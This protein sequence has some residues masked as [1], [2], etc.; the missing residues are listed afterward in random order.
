MKNMLIAS[1]LVMVFALSTV[2]QESE[3]RFA[4][5]PNEITRL[6]RIA[7]G[8]CADEEKAQPIWKTIASDNPELFLF[9]GDNVYADINRDQWVNEPDV[10]ALEFSYGKLEEH[11]EFGAFRKTVPILAGWDDHDYG[12]NDGGRD[13]PIKAEAKELMMD[14][15][16]VPKSDP[17][18][19]RDG[20]YY[21]KTYGPEF[22]RVQII[23][24]DTRWF[25]S[26]LT[27]TDE[28]GAVG[29]ERYLPSDDPEQTMLGEKQWQWLA[30]QLKQPAEVRLLISGIQVESDAHGWEAWR[31]MPL[32]RERLYKLIE[33]SKAEGLVMLSGDRHVGGFYRV[34][35]KTGYPLY[36]FT[37]SSLNKS[38]AQ[39][40]AIKEMGPNQMGQ[41]FG[42]ENY[43]MITVDW[44]DR[45][46]S[47]ELKDIGGK[48]VRAVKISLDDLK[49]RVEQ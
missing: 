45:I 31:T 19:N 34:D 23:M 3:K 4:P 7:F 38:F 36:E 35:G 22:Q 41:L 32:E 1:A 11:A 25:R 29:K 49:Y 24:L 40:K 44:D 33:S 42:P 15:F 5:L 26:D 47:L 13:F 12:I 43:G 2:A 16:E 8:S 10:K 28:R 6:T 39:G 46:L 14:F 18:R 30:E 48:A 37:S 27:V 9:I 20:V 17:V 21:S